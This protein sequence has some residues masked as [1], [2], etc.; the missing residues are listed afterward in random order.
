M[1]GERLNDAKFRV[2]IDG[3]SPVALAVMA[4]KACV[5]ILRTYFQPSILH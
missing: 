5:P 1:K 2:Q 3:I 4:R